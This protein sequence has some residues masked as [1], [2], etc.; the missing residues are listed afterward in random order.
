MSKVR[1]KKY[2]L[3][4][5]DGKDILKVIG[6]TL[7]SAFVVVALDIVQAIEFPAQYAF[8]VPIINTTL[9][10]VKKWVQEKRD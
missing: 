5:E 8:V 2:Q 4:K 7:L 6:W 10:A 3:N 9:V 1:S